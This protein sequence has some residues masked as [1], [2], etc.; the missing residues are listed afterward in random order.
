[1]T[2]VTEMDAGNGKM[3][4][5][6]KQRELLQKPPTFRFLFKSN[7]HVEQENSAQQKLAQVIIDSADKPIFL[8]SPNYINIYFFPPCLLYCLFDHLDAYF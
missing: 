5:R 3:K 2:D 7:S 8:P 6:T 4:M 1:M